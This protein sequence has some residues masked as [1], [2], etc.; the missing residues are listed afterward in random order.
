MFS[1]L[2]RGEWSL[3]AGCLLTLW[4]NESGWL[5]AVVSNAQKLLALQCGGWRR[6]L[7][8]PDKE[9]ARMRCNRSTNICRYFTPSGCESHKGCTVYVSHAQPVVML[10]RCERWK[11][12]LK[13]Q[14]AYIFTASLFQN[15]TEV[16]TFCKNVW[17]CRRCF[18]KRTNATAGGACSLKQARPG[19]VLLT[20]V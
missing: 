8:I 9:L 19:P 7:T 14:C 20:F 1:F 5:F 2:R 6:H 16:S 13:Q 3:C 10:K 11:V 12:L 4:T 18:C 15:A 17:L